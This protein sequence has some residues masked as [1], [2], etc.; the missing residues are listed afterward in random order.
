[1]EPPASH[2]GPGAVGG[3]GAVM[4]VGDEVVVRH[5]EAVAITVQK[6]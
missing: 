1:M 4:K 6:S 2:K 3:A 5:T